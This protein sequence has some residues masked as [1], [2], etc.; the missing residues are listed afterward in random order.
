MDDGNGVEV[1]GL[2]LAEAIAIALATIWVKL[3]FVTVAR[4]TVGNFF[5]I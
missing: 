4:S 5:V 2:L 1:D 3:S